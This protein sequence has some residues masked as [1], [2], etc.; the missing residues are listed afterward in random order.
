MRSF[1]YIVNLVDNIVMS[2][3][4]SLKRTASCLKE[5]APV[6]VLHSSSG[7]L[8]KRKKHAILLMY[9]GWGYYGM[10]RS[11]VY[12]TIEGELSKALLACG[13]LNNISGEEHRRVHFQRASKT[14]KSVSALGQVCSMNLMENENLREELNASLPET[15]RV[16]DIIRVTRKFSS[17]GACSHRVYDYLLPTFALSPRSL[18]L[19]EESHWA[20]RISAEQLAKVNHVMERFKGTHNFFNFTSGRL[21]SDLSCRRFIISAECLSPFLLNDHEFCVIRIVGQ[22]FMLH[23]IRKMVGLML[24]VVRGYA[25]EHVFDI[26]FNTKRVDI[27]KAPSLG[28]MLNQVVFD[29]YNAKYAGDGVHQA[30]DWEKYKDQR[31]SFQ[32]QHIYEHIHKVEVEERSMINWLPLLATHSYDY[33]D[34]NDDFPAIRKI[35]DPVEGVHLGNSSTAGINEDSQLDVLSAPKALS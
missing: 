35:L 33:R 24:G 4:N 19:D 22:S 30:I 10:Q 20:Y 25:L 13:Q 34:S 5:V 1:S 26:A 27:P 23:Q 21:P 6:D 17:K 29:R 31:D 9:S 32:R 28:L 14:D 11:P 12:P 15:V 18:S 2:I 8:E 7:R 3:S 16:L